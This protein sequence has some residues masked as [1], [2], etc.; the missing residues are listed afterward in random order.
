MTLTEALNKIDSH[1]CKTVMI[2]GTLTVLMMPTHNTRTMTHYKFLEID[3]DQG[4]E[5]TM[6]GTGGQNVYGETQGFIPW[7]PNAY[8]LLSTEWEVVG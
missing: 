2:L 1:A 4:R 6:P 5:R 3:C 7:V 8:Q